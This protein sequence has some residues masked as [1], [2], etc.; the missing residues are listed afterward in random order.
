MAGI[1]GFLEFTYETCEDEEFKGWLPT[2]DTCLRVN[3]SNAVEY[4]YYEK[5]MTSTKAV[6]QRAAMDENSKINILSNDM[7]RRLLN[8]KEELGAE[9][10]GAVV[11]QYG[12]KLLNSGYNREQTQRILKNGIKGF[13]TKRRSSQRLGRNLRS[14]ANMSMMKRHKKKLLEKSNWYKKRKNNATKE[15]KPWSSGKNDKRANKVELKEQPVPKTLLFVEHTTG[16]EL[17]RRLR[18][19]L[20]RLTPTIGFSVKVVERAGNPLRSSF[21]LAS[22]W[23]DV[24]CGRNDCVPCD[25]GAEK[26][27]PCYRSSVV[28]ENIC[29][30]CNPGADLS[31]EQP[32]LRADIPTV[33][34]G[35]PSRSMHERMKEHWGAWRSKKEDSHM[36]IH[37]QNEHGGAEEPIFQVRAVQ[38]YK[39]ALTRQLGEA[40]RIRR[41]GGAGMILNSKSEYDRCKI[42]RLVL[43]EDTSKEQEEIESRELQSLLES[44]NE[45]EE[46]WGAAKA[47]ERSRELM[48]TNAELGPLEPVRA[49]KREQEQTKGR[50]AKKLKYA[51]LGADWG[52]EKPNQEQPNK[53]P[54]QPQPPIPLPLHT[55]SHGSQTHGSPPR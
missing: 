29:K 40:V 43:E 41:R 25:Q 36:F 30:T 23:D 17:A 13:E 48:K 51:V 10:R 32:E 39:S 6:Q 14:T 11:D 44:L 37:Q 20:R 38:F 45:E 21:P 53:Q 22:L 24:K 15:E 9:V 3:S 19:L 18:E 33:Y 50:K 7:M 46:E 35:E 31:K 2:L 55:L 1:E 4:R 26:I 8:T 5:P 52:R 12:A 49:T 16:G 34:V 47:K 54:E 28:Y 27:Q 42:P